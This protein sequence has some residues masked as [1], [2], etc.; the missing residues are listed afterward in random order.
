MGVLAEHTKIVR[1]KTRDWGDISARI[2][3]GERP[4]DIPFLHVSDLQIRVDWRALRRWNIL[5]SALP[6]G[7]VI[8]YREPTLWERDRKY[9]IPAIVLIAA[10]LLLIAGLLWERAT[11]RKAAVARLRESEKRFRVMADTTPS[12]VWM[13]DPQRKITY[14]NDR[15]IALT[16]PYALRR[17]GTTVGNSEVI[18]VLVVRSSAPRCP[19][20]DRRTSIPASGLVV[21]SGTASRDCRY[22]YVRFLGVLIRSTRC[23]PSNNSGCRW[24]RWFHPCFF[25]EKTAH[26]KTCDNPFGGADSA[27][28]IA[29][30]GVRR[31]TFL[32]LARLAQRRA[33]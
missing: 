15:R 7:S 11:K 27:S 12:Q 3:L 9:F 33:V 24:N 31:R 6:P 25:D 4:E 28:I 1:K 8:L 26:S 5:E 17:S 29:I 20:C 10:L 2:L 21:A 14:L 18:W 22:G 32:N 30:S 19:V 23:L 13:C 16:R